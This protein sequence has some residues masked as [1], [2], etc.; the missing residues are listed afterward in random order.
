MFS[1]FASNGLLD[2]FSDGHMR[3]D[4]MHAAYPSALA[5]VTGGFEKLAAEPPK[6]LQRRFRKPAPKVTGTQRRARSPRKA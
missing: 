3:S 1:I 6:P 5:F 2:I 4:D